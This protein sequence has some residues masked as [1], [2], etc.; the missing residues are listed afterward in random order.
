MTGRVPA[1][2]G[3]LCDMQ[4][5]VSR[6]LR[7]LP[8]ALV[9]CLTVW[10][11]CDDEPGFVVPD[12]SPLDIWIDRQ[13][14]A[15]VDATNL[16]QVQIDRFVEANDIDTTVTASGL[17]YEMLKEGSGASPSPTDTVL[18]SYRGYLVDGRIFDQST[19]SRPTVR[20]LP[21]GGL[22][23]GFAE[24]LRAMRPGGRAWVLIRPDLG[25]GDRRP[26]ALITPSTVIVFE[27]ELV[28]V[29]AGP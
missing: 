12:Q 20:S 24:A 26:N 28:D 13:D 25:Y 16:P 4:T 19:A 15:F 6:P 21:S 10:S 1:G 3:V 2:A 8:L 23:P 27:I 29:I 17:V 9:A 18:M 11:A 22:I 14:I 5:S 7:T